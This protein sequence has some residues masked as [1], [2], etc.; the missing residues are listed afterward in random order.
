MASILKVDKLDPQSGTALEIGTSGDTVS[1]PSGAT[2]D[3]SASTLTPPATMPASSGINF[4]AL[5]ATNL[6]SGTVPTARLGTGTASSSTVLYGDNTWAAGGGG[7]VVKVTTALP[8]SATANSTDTPAAHVTQAHT[9]ESS[10]NG[11]IVMGI[12]DVTRGSGGGGIQVQ[13]YDEASEKAVSRIATVADNDSIPIPS[14]YDGG[15]S[16]EK[17]WYV[18]VTS[19]SNNSKATINAGHGIVFIEVDTS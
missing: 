14:F 15:Y 2:L 4:T 3:I 5:N 18:Y 8:V 16:G 11:L 17:T 19:T 6:G 10:S 9:M 13:V 7:K 12:G 1:I